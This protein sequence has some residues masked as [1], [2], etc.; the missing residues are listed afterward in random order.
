MATA[1]L[2]KAIIHNEDAQNIIIE[3][4]LNQNINE[5]D[6]SSSDDQDG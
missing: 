5:E 6:E 3:K 4:D 1:P 2:K